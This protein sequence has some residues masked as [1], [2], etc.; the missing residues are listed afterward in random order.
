MV[1]VEPIEILAVEEPADVLTEPIDEVADQCSV[2]A[3][4][5]AHEVAKQVTEIHEEAA[6]VDEALAL[7]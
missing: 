2:E 3:A 7:V 1:A 5:E 4:A 6:P